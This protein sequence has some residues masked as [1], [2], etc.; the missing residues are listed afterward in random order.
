MTKTVHASYYMDWQMLSTSLPGAKTESDVRDAVL[1]HGS[2]H[3]VWWNGHEFETGKL[4]IDVG[5]DYFRMFPDEDEPHERTATLY[6]PIDPRIRIEDVK[7]ATVA[8]PNRPPNTPN[9]CLLYT[10]PSPRDS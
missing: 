4:S 9:T 3:G 7:G 10:S 6:Y 5:G 8:Y 2:D 1:I